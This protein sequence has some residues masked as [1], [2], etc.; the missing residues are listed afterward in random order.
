MTEDRQLKTLHIDGERTW[1]GGEQQALN[2]AAGLRDRGHGV[3]VACQPGSPMAERSRAAGLRCAEIR[4]RSEVD[5]VAVA[6]LARLMRRESFDIIHMHTSHAHTLGCLAARLAGGPLCVVS[7][8]VDFDIRRGMLSG[9]KYRHGVDRYIAISAAVRQVMIDGGV[10]AGRISVVHSGIDLARF[11][12]VDAAGLAE[13][14]GLPASTV[15]IGNVAAMA[16]HK[17]QRYLIEAVPLVA[18]EEPDTKFFIVGDGELKDD[19][20]ERAERLGVT[21][22]IIFTGF[23][24]DVPRLLAYF[25]VFVMSSH[26]EGLCT[27]VMDALAMSKPVVASRAG[28]IPEI[29]EH[30]RNGLLVPP[31][32]PPALAAAIVRMIRDTELRHRLSGAA[33]GRIERHFSADAMVEGTLGAYR[34]LMAERTD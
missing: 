26:M 23:R 22:R 4:M 25:D 18:A 10:D 9:W 11:D 27:S 19:L 1:R 3:V 20:R 29:V 17:G 32:D 31:K 7:R 6:R 34:E 30:E 5:P 13:E 16:D 15:K 28:G 14:F 24:R 2:L 21:D 33:R 12:G 8:R